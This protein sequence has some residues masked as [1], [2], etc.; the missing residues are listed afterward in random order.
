MTESHFCSSLLCRPTVMPWSSSSFWELEEAFTLATTLLDWVLPPRWDTS[1]FILWFMASPLSLQTLAPNVHLELLVEAER[2]CT[3][4][5]SFFSLSKNC[6]TFTAVHTEL[7]QQQL[8][9]PLWR[10]STSA[11]RHDDLVPYCFHVCCR[12]T[13]RC[14]QCQICLS[15][16]GKVSKRDL[17]QHYS[18]VA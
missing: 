7:H 14:C 12:G 9:W 8:V 5:I 16:A 1:L 4:S 6:T 15:L 2:V 11:D 10:A 3:L 13:L 17:M 18:P